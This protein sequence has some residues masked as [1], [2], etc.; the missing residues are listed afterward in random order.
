M[1]PDDLEFLQLFNDYSSQS[2]IVEE[3]FPQLTEWATSM[4]WDVLVRVPLRPGFGL[5]AGNCFSN[6]VA[7]VARDGGVAEYGRMFLLV[8][9]Q[10][11]QTTSHVIW[12][13][14]AGERIDITPLER[15]HTQKHVLFAPDPSVEERRGRS[16]SYHYLLSTNPKVRGI[17]S[18]HQALEDWMAD[19]LVSFDA[20]HTLDF[21][22][23]DRIIEESE[24]PERVK[25]RIVE[26]LV[27]PAFLSLRSHQPGNF[28]RR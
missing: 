27:P 22:R 23:L 12:V 5:S 28:G 16:P 18:L 10:V 17:F 2:R 4:G 21:P 11:I 14:P 15:G 1:N 7:R 19:G 26:N 24:L 3:S 20:L 25:T 9:E 8:P 13:S 6:V